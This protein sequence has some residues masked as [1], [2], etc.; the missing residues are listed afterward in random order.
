[1]NDADK[2]REQLLEELRALRARLE[3]PRDE[4]WRRQ[5]EVLQTIFDHIPVM[6]RFLD[7]SGR[8]RLVNRHWEQ[9]LGWSAEEAQNL[10][11]FAEFYPDPQDRRQVA[12]YIRQAPPGWR[13]FKTRVRD[14]RILDTSWANVVLSDGT[15]I[16]FGLDVT[17][18]KRAEEDRERYA[19]RLQA[20]SRRLVEVQEEERRH[21]ARELHDEIGQ[22]LTGLKSA[23]EAGAAAPPEAARAKLGEARVLADEALTRVSELS[24]DL[25]P[26]LLDHLGLLP[27][28][29]WLVERYTAATGVH[30]NFQHAGLDRRF[31][32]EL[33]TAAYRI[34]Q[35]ALTNVARHARVREA[36]VRLWL[37]ANHLAVQVED[38]GVG[39]D[40]DAVRAA[41]RFNGLTGMHERVLLLGGRWALESAPGDGT[42][43]LAEL[44]LAGHTG[45]KIVEHFHRLGR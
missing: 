14:G 20:L 13:D 30:V 18:R 3:G 44:P 36:A 17:E 21:L 43:V 10:D 27:A 6:I 1:M 42:Q 4:E 22:L 41:G 19:A 16:G 29:R 39:F 24:F 26:A 12:E 35:E 25:R 28:L 2:S 11:V 9:V 32:P 7:S 31:A 40:P 8:V 23:L 37:D 38:Q 15:R 34:V 45:T 33:E 5:K